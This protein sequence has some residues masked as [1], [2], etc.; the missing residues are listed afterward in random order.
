MSAS[1]PIR[2]PRLLRQ[3]QQKQQQQSVISNVH[4]ETKQPVDFQNKIVNNSKMGVRERTEPRIVTNKDDNALDKKLPKPFP[5]SRSNKN[6]LDA[7]RKI[8]KSFRKNLQQPVI[9]KGESNK[10][11][12]VNILDSPE[13]IKIDKKPQSPSK[14]SPS[15][16][17]SKKIER[18]SPKSDKS[19]P[20]KSELS[21]Q[22][23]DL[24]V[25][26]KSRNYMRRNRKAA[27]SPETTLDV[28][29]RLVAPLPE[30]QSRL[31]GEMDEDK[32]KYEKF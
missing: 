15:K 18:Y 16:H 23:K 30:K 10:I 21:A 20:P 32:S 5:K 6:N 4:L 22:F 26:T 3:Q 25:S 13:K 24:K 12:A 14:S 19:S 1:R 27:E 29:L 8:V 7:S 17:K 28:D 9:S 2:D 31:Q 11:T